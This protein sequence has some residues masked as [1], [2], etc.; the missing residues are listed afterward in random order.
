M[1]IFNYSTMPAELLTPEVMNLVSAIHEF[2]GKQELY[3]AAKPDI[4]ISL[5]SVAKVQSTRASNRIEGI[6]TSETRLE[7]LMQ[8]TTEPTSRPE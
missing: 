1:R 5:S 6:Y 2:K 4:L 3:V 8:E 7:A